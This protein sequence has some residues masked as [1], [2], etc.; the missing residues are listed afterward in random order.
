VPIIDWGATRAKL[1]EIEANLA[2]LK[3]LLEPIAAGRHW[4]AL[5]TSMLMV[6]INGLR[7]DLEEL[8]ARA[9]PVIR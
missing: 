8:V 2:A 1:D 4:V 3:L 9:T 5:R 6:E 7:L